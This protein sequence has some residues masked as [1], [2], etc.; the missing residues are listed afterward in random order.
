[1]PM[2]RW[3]RAAL[4]VVAIVGLARVAVA[5]EV[6]NGSKIHNFTGGTIAWIDNDTTGWVV[7]PLHPL[8]T[9]DKNRDRDYSVFTTLLGPIQELG[10][11]QSAQMALAVPLQQYGHLAL[12]LSYTTQVVSD[13]DSVNVAMNLYQTTSG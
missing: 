11:G 12:L 9:D 8:P 2:K 4:V 10:P 13:S 6:A 3:M 1:M 5:M 7:S